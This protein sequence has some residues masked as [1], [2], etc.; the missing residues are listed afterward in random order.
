MTRDGDDKKL[1]SVYEH[2][3]SAHGGGAY[4]E[5]DRS[6]HPRPPEMLYDFVEGFR[7][8]AG[9]PVLDVGCGQGGHACELARRFDLRATGIDPVDGNLMIARETAARQ[10]LS[11]RVTFTK[12]SMESIPFGDAEFDLI[13]CRDMLVHVRGLRQGL[14]ECAR[15]LRPGGHM[16]VFTTYATG[17]ME[18]R[19]AAR[20]YNALGVVPDNTSLAHVED[21]FEDAGL[22]ILS[23]ETIG[24]ELVQYYEERDGRC[25]R[26]LMRL[27]RMI[28]AGEKFLAELGEARYEV[29]EA[30]YHWVIYQ[31]IGK[32]SSA[33]YTLEKADLSRVAASPESAV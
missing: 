12:G 5:L 8:A 13:W 11:G 18:P 14:G 9:S 31:L 3:W 10:S 30:L 32:L 29:A 4:E 20:I 21:C 22:R 6:L 15:V 16:L 27:A 19:E 1:N 23:R 28:Q 7:L 33:I 2:I 26:E 17:R 25:R 24:S